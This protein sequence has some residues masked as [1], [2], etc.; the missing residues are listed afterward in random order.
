MPLP[1][2]LNFGMGSLPLIT[3]AE[4]RS[5]SAENPDGARGGGARA[6]P[7]EDPNCMPADSSLGQ[8]WKVRPCVKLQP[9][10]TTTVADIEGPGIIQQ[11]WMT[12]GLSGCEKSTS[13]LCVIRFY[14]DD[15]EEPS[16]ETPIGEF[17]ALGHNICYNVNSMPISVV[18]RGGMNSYWPMP[19]RKRARV[20]IENPTGKE[21]AFFYQINYALSDV[22]DNAAYFHTQYRRTLTT[23]EH[24]EHVILDG[25]KGPG[26]YVGT[27]IAWTQMSSGWWGEGEAK[28][29]IDG[30]GQFPTICTTGTEDYFGGSCGFYEPLIENPQTYC[31]PFLGYPLC[32][33]EPKEV[34]RH[35]LYRW[36]IM[37]P[38]R[39]KSDIKATIQT[40]GWWPESQFQPLTDDLASTAF[41]YQAE[42]HAPFPALPGYKERFPR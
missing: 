22:P 24:P 36:H 13:L 20:T 23:R 16:V 37:D 32:R 40:I 14:W 17:F 42:P 12:L 29:Y 3:D 19:F 31:T 41:W 10:T 30:D 15:E 9:G 2:G 18:P 26:H 7:G 28:F 8:G 34:P 38:I 4:T 5:I 11:M 39:F 33:Y 25:V 21:E 35:A 1:H 6:L 27:F